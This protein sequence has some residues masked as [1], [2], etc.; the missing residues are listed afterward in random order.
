MAELYVD[1]LMSRPVET[2]PARTTVAEAAETLRRHAVG[3]LVVTDEAGQLDG[4]L[5]ATDF[6]SMVA[7][8]PTSGDATVADFMQTDVVTTTRETPA[9]EVAAVMLDHL[10]HHVPVVEGQEVVGMLTTM[11]LAA[12]VARTL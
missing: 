5:T 9:S 10:I 6:I 7:G 11:D 4:L 1:E 2:V 3:A 8:E 12:Y